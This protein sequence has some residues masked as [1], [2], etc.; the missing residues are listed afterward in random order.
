MLS[1]EEVSAGYI[2]LQ[3]LNG[4]SL[5]VGTGKTVIILGPNG[6]GKS[7]LLNVIV[8]LLKPTSGAICFDGQ[9]IDGKEAYEI[10]D[11]GISIVL[12]GGRLFPMLSVYENLKIGTYTK[13]ARKYFRERIEQI[14]SL[15]PILKERQ[16]QMAGS[17]S[18][19]ERQML[20][21]ARTLMLQPKIVIL[22]EP[23]SGLAP[24]VVANV[25]EFIKRI[26]SEGY[27][28]LMSE[29]NAK[30]ALEI[31]DY[32][33]L[34]ESGRLKFQGS[35]EDFLENPEIKRAYLGI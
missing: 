13:R 31:A 32:A 15:F 11:M 5:E 20:A 6:A 8:G 30:K 35:Q 14:F 26:K 1:I 9:R 18:G 16:S 17:L 24:I 10:A 3:V 33:Y 2:E 28:I 4:V 19:G 23:S 7:T 34:M 12:E 21:I 27:S 29:Q 22:D 25:F